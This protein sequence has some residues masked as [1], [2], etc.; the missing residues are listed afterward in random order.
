[1]VAGTRRKTESGV[2]LR[3]AV[4]DAIKA[5]GFADDCKG[6]EIT[7]RVTRYSA[8]DKLLSLRA[9]WKI[10]LMMDL[11]LA[12]NTDLPHNPTPHALVYLHTGRMD[13]ATGSTLAKDGQ[14]QPVSLFAYMARHAQ[15]GPDGK[16]DPRAIANG[17]AYLCDIENKVE[18]INRSNLSHTWAAYHSDPK[19]G[20][21]HVFQPN[22]CMRQI[23]V[24]E[25]FHAV[26][27]YTWGE[28][29]GQNFPQAV[30]RTMLI[31]DEPVAELDFS[32]MVTRMLYHYKRIDPVGDVYRPDVLFPAFHADNPND[33]DRSTV[34]DFIKRATNICWN[35]NSRGNA[36]SS[37][38]RLLTEYANQ[39]FLRS[40]TYDVLERAPC[41]PL[42]S[43]SFVVP[44]PTYLAKFASP[45]PKPIGSSLNHRPTVA[46]YHLARLY[47]RLVS[48]SKN[49]PVKA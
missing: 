3:V 45:P 1:V 14:R 28:L 22:P 25:L 9:D 2:R 17:M 7:R 49:L 34:R 41:K 44:L 30:R 29:S 18:K 36:N 15:P 27:L 8:T 40:V 35:V 16:P 46:S 5:A 12:R 26:R 10:R 6:S 20:R 13:P 21:Q 11:D 38:G 43:F 47:C 33:D 19:S 24:G 42:G 4:W 37:V 23:R 31:D 39:T 32:G 48:S